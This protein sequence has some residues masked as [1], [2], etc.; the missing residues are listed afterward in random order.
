MSFEKYTPVNG[1]VILAEHVRN[2]EDYLYPINVV[3]HGGIQTSGVTTFNFGS[4]F[5]VTTTTGSVTLVITGATTT[6]Q[7]SV[8]GITDWPFDFTG[9]ISGYPLKWDSTLG[10]Y[11]PAPDENSGGG[12]VSSSS[13]SGAL[14]F[15]G[16]YSYTYQGMVEE[17]MITSSYSMSGAVI[18]V[19]NAPSS[20]GSVKFNVYLNN[21]IAISGMNLASSNF[22]VDTNYVTGLVQRDIIK[23]YCTETNEA[24]VGNAI[25]FGIR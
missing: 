7:T 1:D 17:F 4:G 16:I 23:F 24:T 6:V 13:G 14:I 5:Q 11:R 21:N 15:P 9:A 10:K 20:T 22:Y 18:K 25:F 2:I 19:S 8:S 3:N 12:S